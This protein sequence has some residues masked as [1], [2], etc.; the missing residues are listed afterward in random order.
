MFS[1]GRS[2]LLS[3]TAKNSLVLLPSFGNAAGGGFCAPRANIA[4]PARLR[5]RR[6]SVSSCFRR[7]RLAHSP[8]SHEFRRTVGPLRHK[9]SAA[10]N[11]PT[12][13]AGCRY[14]EAIEDRHDG[15][16][17]LQRRPFCG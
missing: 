17:A 14:I 3:F 10:S 15:T 4:R 16:D 7:E 2:A 5:W 1:A 8:P 12:S 6:K 13:N 11:G 9:R